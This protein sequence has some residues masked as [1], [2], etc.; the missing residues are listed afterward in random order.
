MVTAD[1]LAIMLT[2]SLIEEK[3]TGQAL[4]AIFGCLG[5]VAVNIAYW[6]SDFEPGRALGIIGDSIKDWWKERPQ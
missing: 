3:P 2:A 1:I 6:V 5:V 4:L